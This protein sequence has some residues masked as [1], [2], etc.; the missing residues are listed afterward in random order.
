MAAAAAVSAAIVSIRFRASE[1]CPGQR[2][3]EK[4]G[5]RGVESG[6]ERTI[7]QTHTC[8]YSM[9]LY[10]PRLPA[11]VVVLLPLLLLILAHI[12]ALTFSLV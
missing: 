1:A 12:H 7:Q 9:S 5:E 10:R 8:C 3:R 6:S 11:S 2:E 4:E